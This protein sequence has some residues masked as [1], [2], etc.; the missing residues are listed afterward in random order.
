MQQTKQTGQNGYGL[1][2]A[3]VIIGAALLLIYM[4]IMFIVAAT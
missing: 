1:A 4:L 3:G 2:L